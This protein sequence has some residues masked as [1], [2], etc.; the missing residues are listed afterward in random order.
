MDSERRFPVGSR[1]AYKSV[2][3]QHPDAPAIPALCEYRFRLPKDAW[4]TSAAGCADPPAYG[5]PLVP[6]PAS[7]RAES[8]LPSDDAGAQHSTA[9]RLLS[10]RLEKYTAT[11]IPA[12]RSGTFAQVH[13]VATHPPVR[14][15]N[16]ARATPALDSTVVSM[17]QSTNPAESSRGP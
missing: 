8:F 16:P 4:Q 2:S 13:A 9:G 7:Q 14:S 11:P 12:Q 10:P 5:S 17:H 15:T 3:L 6:A 1:H